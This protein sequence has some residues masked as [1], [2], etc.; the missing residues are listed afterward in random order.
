MFFGKR[1]KELLSEIREL[2]AGIRESVSGNEELIHQG[3]ER[4]EALEK[5]TGVHDVVLEDLSD[6]LFELR[7]QESE[8]V[9]DLK[10]ELKVLRDQSQET[11]RRREEELLSLLMDYQKQFDHLE[12]LLSEDEDWKRQFSLI[13]EKLERSSLKAGITLLG[14]AGDAVDYELHEVLD[15]RETSDPGLDRRI[16]QVYETGY[17]CGG[18]IRKARV[19]AYRAENGSEDGDEHSDRN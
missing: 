3:S 16:A 18:R 11:G 5:K 17:A 12:A 7:E 14:K 8:T 9:S 13:R 19:S 15:I 6:S 4:L 2:A 1:E 10:E